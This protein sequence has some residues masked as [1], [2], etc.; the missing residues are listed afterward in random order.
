[1]QVDNGL[2]ATWNRK[3]FTAMPVILFLLATNGTDF[4]KQPLGLNLA[5]VLLC[6]IAKL[7]AFHRVRI[8]GINK[9]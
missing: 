9:Y 7:P 2:Y 4:R 6:M 8:L 5:V 3:L 1:M